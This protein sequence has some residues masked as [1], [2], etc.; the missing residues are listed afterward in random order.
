MSIDP[1]NHHWL[2]MLQFCR[3]TAL[4]TDMKDTAD[5]LPARKRQFF[6]L[7]N[8]REIAT[9]DG[10]PFGY[11]RPFCK[12]VLANRLRRQFRQ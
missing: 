9:D 1:F 7:G 2:K 6:R 8:S 5:T 4:D 3:N 12:T 10:R 11:Q